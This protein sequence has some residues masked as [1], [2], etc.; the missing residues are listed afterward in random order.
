[1]GVTFPERRGERWG[2]RFGKVS[3]NVRGTLARESP[4]Q[5]QEQEQ[6]LNTK[7]CG[8]VSKRDTAACGKLGATGAAREGSVE[9]CSGAGAPGVRSSVRVLTALV[10][11]VMAE[12]RVQVVDAEALESIKAAA[13]KA[14]I[15]WEP[16]ELH[17]AVR[18]AEF[19]VRKQMAGAG[20]G[21]RPVQGWR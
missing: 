14:R 21:D 15:P 12:Q 10:R 17:K 18:S 13:G 3:G 16:N 2:E 4:L 8:S 1:L 7:I 6:E 5:E 19:Q 9:K 20:A 11:A